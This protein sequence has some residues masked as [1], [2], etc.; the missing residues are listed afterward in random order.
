MLCD[1]ILHELEEEQ[2]TNPNGPPKIV[3]SCPI[4]SIRE[5]KADG[6]DIYLGDLG[7]RRFDYQ[8]MNDAMEEEMLVKQRLIDENMAKVVGDPTIVWTVGGE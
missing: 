1:E 3:D 4:R 6:T 2:N 8:D 5:V 7:F